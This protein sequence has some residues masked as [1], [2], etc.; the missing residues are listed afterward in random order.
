MRASVIRNFKISTVEDSFTSSGREF[1]HSITRQLK[2]FFL[3]S[4][5]NFGSDRLSRQLAALVVLF[6]VSHS[7]LK[8]LDSQILSFLL[9][10]FQTCA[11]SETCLLSSKLRSFS[12][13][14]R[15]LYVLLFRP[16]HILTTFSWTASINLM[17]FWD[18]GDQHWTAYSRW[19]HT[20]AL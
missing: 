18:Q 12:S 17:S 8:K 6:D 15:S 2:K 11:M 4:K 13:F 19:G 10:I 5:L 1:Q 3:I 14:S 7:L 16:E 20:Y 9:R